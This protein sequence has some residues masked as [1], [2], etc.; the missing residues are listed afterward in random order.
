MRDTWLKSNHRIDVNASASIALV[1]LYYDIFSG[2]EGGRRCKVGAHGV[3]TIYCSSCDLQCCRS[4]SLTL[5]SGYRT[6][7]G[8]FA[9]SGAQQLC[10]FDFEEQEKIPIV[11]VAFHKKWWSIP[12]QM[13]A[14]I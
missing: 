13:S 4:W 1:E 3:N 2:V 14:E 11:E 12:Q 9:M 8:D 5:D 10:G 6:I 7:F